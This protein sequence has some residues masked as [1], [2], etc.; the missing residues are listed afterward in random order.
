VK[1]IRQETGQSQPP[2][3]QTPGQNLEDLAGHDP[4]GPT[5]LISHAQTLTTR[6]IPE[7]DGLRGI[8]IGMVVIWHYF[9]A[10]TSAHPATLLYYARI[11][12][13]LSWTGV[14]LFFVLSGFLIG[15]ILLD[16]RTAKNY[17]QVFYTRRV[18]RI[19]PVYFALLLVLPDLAA[20]G[21]WTHHGDFSWALG[22]SPPW[23]AYWTFTQNFWMARAGNLGGFCLWMTWSLAVEE[24]FYLT[25]PL[26]LR[27]M[28]TRSFVNCMLVGICAAP[29]VRMTLRLFWPNNWVPGYV[30]MLCR[31]DALLLGVLA[32]GL[33]RDVRWRERIQRSKLAFP[34]LLPV[35]SA[36]IVFL[37][38]KSSSPESPLMGKVGYTWMALSYTLFLI[39]A[40]TRPDSLMSRALRS[41]WLGWLGLI[42]Y[43]TYLFHQPIQWLLFSYFWGGPPAITNSYTLFT[44]LAALLLTFLVARL[45]WRFFE[46]PL[47]RLGHRSD[48][49]FAESTEKP[50][51][52][53]APELVGSH[54]G[55]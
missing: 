53:S 44:T 46:S 24:Q 48:Y 42:A 40:L 31:A 37:N 50:E 41:K 19:F 16:A 32:A 3:T 43:G 20:F 6:R 8:A 52:L 55:S 49:Q 12:G 21:M 2:G 36:G 17:F 10:T 7:L 22:S 51:S 18:F 1:R 27:V 47:I 30:L 13:R 14:D 54:I 11:L 5:L 45:S 28:P 26:F 9:E 15:G 4:Q 39:Y 34:I 35:F 38:L 23:Y 33:I 25:L 29:V